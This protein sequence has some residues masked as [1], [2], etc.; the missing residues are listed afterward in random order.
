MIR[1]RPALRHVRSFALFG[2]AVIFGIISCTTSPAAA[3]SE[4][5]VNAINNWPLYKLPTCGVNATA[6]PNSGT[7]IV[8]DPGH[9]GRSGQGD[10]D[11]ETGLLVGDNDGAPGE[12][13]AMWKTAQDVE[14][15]LKKKG[16]TVFLTKKSQDA[17][18]DLKQRAQITDSHNAT[19]AVS[20]HYDGAH[21]FHSWGQIYDQEVGLKRFNY[22]AGGHEDTSTV[23]KFSNTGVAAK[24]QAAAQIFLKDRQKIEK[25]PNVEVTHANFGTAN[26]PS[27]GT[28]YSGGNIPM[29][30]LLSATPWV[31]NEV[32]GIGFDEAAYVKS[33]TTSIEEAAPLNGTPTNPDANAG[34]APAGG[35]G[36]GT[37]LN[38]FKLPAT[39]GPTGAEEAINAAGQVGSTGERVAWPQFANISKDGVN[40]RDYYINMRWTFASW[41]WDGHNKIV[42]SKQLAWMG[43]EPRK[44]LVTNPKSGKSIVAVIM[45]SGPAPYVGSSWWRGHNHRS[46]TDSAPPYWQG[47]KVGTPKGYDGLVSGFPPKAR[48]ALGLKSA[49]LGYEGK[50]VNLNYAWADQNASVGPTDATAGTGDTGCEDNT[51][52]SGSPNCNAATGNAKILCEAKKYNGIYYGFGAAHDGFKPFKARCTATVLAS[53]AKKS[54]P[55]NIGPCATDCSSLVSIAVDETFNHTYMWTVSE[56]GDATMQGA[57]ASNWKSVPLKEAQ[58]GDIVTKAGHVEIVDHIDGSKLY[59]F[60]SHHTGTRTIERGPINVTGYYTHAW[61]WQE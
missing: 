45:E 50:G 19:L 7:V 51:N 48:A 33:I 47:Y 54:T 30:Q 32:G 40:Y 41:S 42:D 38:G 49:D 2:A 35:G 28:N 46:G 27:R 34:G 29:V 36:T 55:G 23:R 25:D 60:G 21:S 10:K 20:L 43:K 18:V 24:S 53:A 44:V 56:G 9:S 61:R 17:Y 8:L 12:R 15:A 1:A 16:Y 13:A 31:Y 26:D 57:G 39:T 4:A 37:T 14:S 5:D 11:P 52:T 22:K 6:A 59:T 3:L 58:P